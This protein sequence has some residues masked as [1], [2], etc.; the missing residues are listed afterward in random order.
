MRRRLIAVAAATVLAG[1]GMTLPALADTA[2]SGVVSANPVDNTPHIMD[3]TVRA[4]AVVGQTV[5]VGGDFSRVTDAS[6]RTSYSRR[7][8]FAYDLPTG[9]VQAF[10]PAVDGPV[11]ALAGGPSNTVYLG[12]SFQRVQGGAQRGLARVRLADSTRVS[13]FAASINYGDVRSVVA[14]GQWIYA[15]GTF[16]AVNGVK[17]TALARV[18]AAN[19]AVD[20]GMDLALSAP[21]LH[22]AKVEDLTVSPNGGT[23]VAVGAIEQ[24]GGEYRAQLVVANTA[25]S[26]VRVADWWTDAFSG[27]CRAGF[28][29]Y[30]RGVDFSPGGDYF[31]AVTTGRLSGPERTCDSA[32]RFNTAG[33]GEHP[34]V[35]INHTGGDSL[36]AVSVTGPAVYLGGHQRWMDNPQGHES[37]GPGAVSRTGIAAIDPNTGR[38]LNW[39]PTRSRGVGV[40]ALVSTSSGLLVGSDT[41]QLGKE[42]HGRIGMFPPA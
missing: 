5:V 32:I 1:F 4:I 31:V 27:P 9:K 11:L 7:N 35:W 2:Q 17:R 20:N 22:R 6:R 30:L 13:T 28:D 15:G 40:R 34:P 38:A 8:I 39:N 33:T 37:A 42:Y 25:T 10:A 14:S 36:Y 18:S 16:T 23:L 21:S 26:P 3:G 41:D 12:G 24:A 29:T 19:G